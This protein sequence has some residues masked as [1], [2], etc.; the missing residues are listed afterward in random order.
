[1]KIAQSTLQKTGIGL[2]A[3]IFLVMFTLRIKNTPD[4]SGYGK[5]YLISDA[6]KRFSNE[7][8]SALLLGL[9]GVTGRLEVFYLS[10]VVLFML[11]LLCLMR[12]N[13]YYSFPFFVNALCN[14]FV[15]I[16]FY[17]PR[18][19]LAV[20]V[21]L[22]LLSSS[23]IL[24]RTIIHFVTFCSHNFVFFVNYLTVQYLRSRH[25]K[26]FAILA[27]LVIGVVAA[28]SG[29]L[30]GTRFNL[31]HYA[32]A[33]TEPR[34]ITRNYYF[35]AVVVLTLLVQ[36]LLNN[37]RVNS[38]FALL[39]LASIYLVWLNPFANRIAISFFIFYYCTYYSSN[40]LS[41]RFLNVTLLPVSI[42]TFLM[43]IVSGRFGYG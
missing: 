41:F 2:F 6:L 40:Q 14:P 19:S 4:F 26:R 37:G 7:P 18:N 32:D 5:Y 39:S 24:S 9:S 42:I 33:G 31:V 43:V 20:A 22:L 21:G 16:M 38:G 3:V 13:R 12:K 34:G 28:T 10:G 25:L 1:M 36:F 30:A 17:V 11:A 23:N 15:L 27:L 35:L 8:F 29:L